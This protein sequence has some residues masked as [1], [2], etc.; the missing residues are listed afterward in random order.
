M[1]SNCNT[2]KRRADRVGGT[3]RKAVFLS[4]SLKLNNIY[5]N[6]VADLWCLRRNQCGGVPDDVAGLFDEPR[7]PTK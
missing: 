3:L 2:G 1:L 6:L 7:Q 4:N 5:D